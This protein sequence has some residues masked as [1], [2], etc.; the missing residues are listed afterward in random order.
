[1]D[2]HHGLV[3]LVEQQAP[4]AGLGDVVSEEPLQYQ[5]DG[6]QFPQSNK[7]CAIQSR[8]EASTLPLTRGTRFLQFSRSSSVTHICRVAVNREDGLQPMQVPS[9]STVR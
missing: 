4:D 1:M 3:V 8:P 7:L 5:A 6:S 9:V 2:V